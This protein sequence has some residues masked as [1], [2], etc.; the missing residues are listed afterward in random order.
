MTKNRDKIVNHDIS[1]K[2]V[3]FLPYRPPLATPIQSTIVPLRG[4]VHAT[5]VI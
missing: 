1:K 4:S 2:K 5:D 3:I